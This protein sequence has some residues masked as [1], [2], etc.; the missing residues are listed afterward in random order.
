MSAKTT[1]SLLF[2][3]LFCSLGIE[4]QD[5]YQ[6][7]AAGIAVSPIE[8]SQ[9]GVHEYVLEIDRQDGVRERRLYRDGELT[10]TERLVVDGR[11]RVLEEERY[12]EGVLR[13][14]RVYDERGAVGEIRHYDADGELE[15]TVELDYADGRRTAERHYGPD[16]E[17]AYTDR[18]SYGS[19]GRVREVERFRDGERT[20]ITRYAYAGGRLFEEYFQNGEDETV[21]R[22]D[23]EGRVAYRAERDAGE[24]V[25][26][27]DYRYEGEGVRIVRTRSADQAGVTIERYDEGLLV[28]SRVEVEGEIISETTREYEE[29]RLSRVVRAGDEIAGRRIELYEYDENGELVRRTVRSD[30]RTLR[31]VVYT[32]ER[33]REEITYRDGEPFLRV[34]Y[35]DDN[36][37]ARE[38]VTGE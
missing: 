34:T 13:T 26:E 29:G 18:F 1:L 5:L 20:R 21:V 22:Y 9:R 36:P 37:V 31:E 6:S 28:S 15:T 11:G 19:N 27:Q 2:V 14:A 7:N 35:R 16:G 33:T 10:T 4:A 25:R 23:T 38:L 8:A 30:G 24:L 12:E 32:G 17:L 3:L